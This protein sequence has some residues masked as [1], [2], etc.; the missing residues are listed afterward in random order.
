MKV[1]IDAIMLIADEPVTE[2]QIIDA[3]TVEDAMKKLTEDMLEG[4]KQAKRFAPTATF[5]FKVEVKIQGA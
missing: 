4:V 5:D 1:S 2:P 3:S